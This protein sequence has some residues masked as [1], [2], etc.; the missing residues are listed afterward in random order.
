MS[1][2]PTSW[3]RNVNKSSG[4]AG[5]TPRLTTDRYASRS[6][7]I[8]PAKLEA[9]RDRVIFWRVIVVLILMVLIGVVVWQLKS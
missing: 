3:E 6:A 5:F 8:N 2:D 1:D 4:P 9:A 7:R